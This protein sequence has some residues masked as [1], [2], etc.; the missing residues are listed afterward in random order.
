VSYSFQIATNLVKNQ[1]TLL[2]LLLPQR[3]G[4]TRLC[5]SD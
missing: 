4:T 1:W 2:P 3:S 5:A